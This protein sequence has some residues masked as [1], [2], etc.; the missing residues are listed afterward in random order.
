MH[1]VTGFKFHTLWYDYHLSYQPDVIDTLSQSCISLIFNYTIF[2]I[3]FNTRTV[4]NR[5]E[6]IF[7][8]L[9]Q[10]TRHLFQHHSELLLLFRLIRNFFCHYISV[11][12][13]TVAQI[14]NSNGILLWPSS[15]NLIK[16]LLSY[17]TLT[18]AQ[19]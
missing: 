7:K 1:L 10:I 19:N 8:Y 3:Y 16:Y 15:S 9:A 18:H 2:P 5:K 6:F 17:S 14:L 4:T 12:A 11:S 13:P